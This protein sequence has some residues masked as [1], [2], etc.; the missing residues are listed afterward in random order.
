MLCARPFKFAIKLAMVAVLAWIVTG[1]IYEK[2]GERRD[3]NRYA[4]IGR[5]VDIG[6]RTLNLYCSGMGS[7][8]V[9]FEAPGHTAGFTWINVQPEVA[10]LTLACWYDRAGYGWS[11]PGPSP[12]TFAAAAR[13]LHALVHAAGLPPPYVL[14]GGNGA[15]SMH[16][17][18]YNAYYPKDVAGAVLTGA[19]D[20]D[21]EAHEP[22]YMKGALSSMPPWAMRVG[23]GVV[24]PALLNLGLLRLAGNPGAGRANVFGALTPEQRQELNFLSTNPSTARTEGEGCRH[25]ESDEEVRQAGNFGDR[26]LVVVESS[27]PVPAPN[28]ELAAATQA[29]N[30]YW[31]H[32]L[33]PRLAGLST[34]GRLVIAKDPTA[35][36]T[37]VDAVRE[38]VGK[39][40]GAT[41]TPADNP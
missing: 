6:G 10:K 14:V 9:I 29:F 35:L 30:D 16:V 23:C 4:Q 41:A 12:R 20:P 7:P 37:V 24:V 5:S 8:T 40:R 25:E 19:A 18:V 2:L 15:A 27:E 36:Q 13:D 39:V 22:P 17:R 21:E 28:P 33:L 26:P 11:D 3:R 31:F 34:H 1:V 38:V 32:Q